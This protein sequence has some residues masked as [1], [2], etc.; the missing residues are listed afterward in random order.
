[1][2]FRLYHRTRWRVSQLSQHS[3]SQGVESDLPVVGRALTLEQSSTTVV[4]DK[5]LQGQNKATFML[6]RLGFVKK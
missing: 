1:M 6:H 3:M 5:L 4:I 2:T